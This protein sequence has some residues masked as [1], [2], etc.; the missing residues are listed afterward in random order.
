MKKILIFIIMIL[1]CDSNVQNDKSDMRLIE[2]G[3]IKIESLSCDGVKRKIE[4][5]LGLKEG[6]MNSVKF[7]GEK[8]RKDIA[9]L[10]SCEEI[11]EYIKGN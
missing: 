3:E 7:C 4:Y 10:N 2:L 5:C 11:K 6:A 1:S 9:I 8:S